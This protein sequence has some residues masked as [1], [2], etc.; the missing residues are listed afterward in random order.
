MSN[1]RPRIQF[2]EK[3]ICSACV[4]NEYKNKIIDWDKKEKELEDALVDNITTFL[5]ELGN[6]FAYVGRQIRLE[7]GKEEFFGGKDE[8]WKLGEYA[9]YPKWRQVVPTPYQLKTKKIKT[10]Q[11]KEAIYSLEMVLKNMK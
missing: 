5:L 2:N 9:K 6:G 4:Y 8:L 10:K 3:G 11:D 1:Q 7:I